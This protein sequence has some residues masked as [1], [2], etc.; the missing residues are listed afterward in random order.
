MIEGKTKYLVSTVLCVLLPQAA[1][2]ATD[3]YVDA[4]A[5][6]DANSGRST[7]TPWRTLAKVNSYT[8]FA[9]GDRILLQRGRTWR[10]QLTV[11][12]S[13]VSGSPIVFGTY[14]TGNK[15]ML[16]GSAL[17][18]NWGSAGSNRWSASLGTAPNQVFFNGVRG[19]KKSGT[20]SLVTARDWYWSSG[21]VRVLREQSGQ[22]LLRSGRRGLN[23]AVHTDLR[24]HPHSRS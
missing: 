23:S 6:N 14:G 15:P 16:K 7:T 18:T 13:G 9:A 2:F 24:H 4:S 19:T 17:V 11:P 10:E 12:R 21:A 5:G 8:G 3:Y 1:C 22:R 20:S